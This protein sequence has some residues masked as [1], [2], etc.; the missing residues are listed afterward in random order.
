MG[1]LNDTVSNH[2]DVI[3]GGF[4]GDEGKGKFVGGIAH[5]YD[6]VMRVNATTNA[7][8]WVSDGINQYVT[9]Q[10][11]SV[12]F[13]TRTELLISPGA[14][15]NLNALVEEVSERPDLTHLYNKV[16]IASSISLVILPYL[17]KDRQGLSEKLGSTKQGT[18]PSAAARAAR[19]S[20]HLY[21]V[22][23]AIYLGKKD[24][25]LDKIKLTCEETLPLQFL[26]TN[27]STQSYFKNIL[28]EL[29]ESYL[30][31]EELVGRFMV[32][33]TDYFNLGYLSNHRS[34]LIEGCNG[35]LLD[36]LHGMH[37]YVTSCSTNIGAMLSYANVSITNIRHI[38]V[39]LSAYSTCLGIRPFPAELDEESSRHFFQNCNEIDVA[40]HKKRRIGW[41]DIPALRKALSGANGAYIHMN[42]L[43]VLSG[44]PSIKICTHYMAKG[45]KYEVL[46][47]NPYIHDQLE[48]QYMELPGWNVPLQSIEA[49]D[50]LPANAKKYVETVQQLLPIP[51]VSLGVGPHNQNVIQI[52]EM[53]VQ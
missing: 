20:L 8:H 53:Q 11:P 52:R 26:E 43:D 7:G 15:L 41:L 14:L 22:H 17:T 2:I 28:E 45:Q 48:A 32:D 10:L 23:A 3:V 34:V 25:V 38:F 27:E 9:R 1:A 35:M 42:K 16:K 46:P 47:D 31:L 39:V 44:L 37:P 24:E 36:N 21:D 40:E 30:H 51:I 50:D 49:F 33:Y 5:Q 4:L 6:A 29:I 19:H 13:P 12:F 18:G